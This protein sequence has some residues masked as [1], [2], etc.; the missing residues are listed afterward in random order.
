[1][2]LEYFTELSS[3][4]EQLNSH[5]PLPNFSCI[6]Q[7]RCDASRIAHVY[8]IEGQ[9]I[10]FLTCLNEKFSVVKTQILLMDPLPSLNKVCH[11]HLYSLSL[12]HY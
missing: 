6:H 2:V 7:C 11:A 1:M 9:I 3:L 5:R 8:R 10:Q 12:S 4:W